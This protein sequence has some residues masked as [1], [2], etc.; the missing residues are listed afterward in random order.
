MPAR[1]IACGVGSACPQ[2]DARLHFS[3]RFRTGRLER[4]D[5]RCAEVAPKKEREYEPCPHFPFPFERHDFVA[6]RVARACPL[7]LR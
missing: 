6:G 1:S 3:R 2:F 5:I 7:Y 4:Q